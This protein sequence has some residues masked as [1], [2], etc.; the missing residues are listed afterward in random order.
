VS[1]FCVDSNHNHAYKGDVDLAQIKQYEM[2][3]KQVFSI[4]ETSDLAS[5]TRKEITKDPVPMEWVNLEILRI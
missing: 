1:L 4:L 3:G 2:Q 5:R